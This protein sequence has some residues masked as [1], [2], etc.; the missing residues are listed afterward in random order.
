MT[1]RLYVH[2]AEIRYLDYG[3]P[4]G[5]RKG[6]MWSAEG[7]VSMAF[8]FE[9]KTVEQVKARFADLKAAEHGFELVVGEK[10]TRTH[11]MNPHG[12]I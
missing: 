10:V 5:T 6:I 12:H 2:P 7:D 1:T 11:D 8:A 4:I 9:E 3:D